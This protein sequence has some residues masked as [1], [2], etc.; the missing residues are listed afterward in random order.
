MKL[1]HFKSD[2]ENFNGIV[3]ERVNEAMQKNYTD[4]KLKCKEQQ[5]TITKLK[6]H[7]KCF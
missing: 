1:A 7:N 3:K 2:M 6:D 5:L 4:L